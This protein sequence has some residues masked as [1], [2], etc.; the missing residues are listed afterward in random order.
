MCQ[1][2]VGGTLQDGDSDEQTDSTYIPIDSSSS[3]L[4]EGKTLSFDGEEVDAL[5]SVTSKQCGCITAAGD[6]GEI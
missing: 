4:M 3:T 2:G 1:A 6:S 5:D